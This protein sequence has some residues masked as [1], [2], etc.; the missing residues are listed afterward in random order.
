MSR[1]LLRL[2]RAAVHSCVRTHFVSRSCALNRAV[3]LCPQALPSLPTGK[4]KLQIHPMGLIIILLSFGAW[5]VALGG[6]GASQ[7]TCSSKGAFPV[8]RRIEAFCHHPQSSRCLR[9]NSGREARSP[10]PPPVL[11]R[12]RAVCRLIVANC[13][14]C[15]AASQVSPPALP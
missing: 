15:P 1:E 12:E 6:V 8:L 3:C 11:R 7:Q 5:V 9:T 13:G 4:K 10:S 14:L 2:A